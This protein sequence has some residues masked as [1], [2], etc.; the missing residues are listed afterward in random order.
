MDTNDKILSALLT[1][2]AELELGR[3]TFIHLWEEHKFHVKTFQESRPMTGANIG[4]ANEL[5]SLY[6][7]CPESQANSTLFV[8]GC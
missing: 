4:P 8:T 1:D 2:S 5:L 6:L 3:Q 7:T